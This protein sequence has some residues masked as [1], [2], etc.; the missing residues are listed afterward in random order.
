MKIDDLVFSDELDE[1]GEME[2]TLCC[3]ETDYVIAWLTERERLA[4]IEHLKKHCPEGS[5]NDY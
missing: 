5:D 2:I 3:S 4:L 1:D